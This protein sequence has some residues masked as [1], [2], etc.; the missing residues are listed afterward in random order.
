[1]KWIQ[2]EYREIRRIEWTT[3]LRLQAR[4]A[5]VHYERLFEND[6]LNT[7]DIRKAKLSF[8]EDS[9]KLFRLKRWKAR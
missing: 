5:A 3:F 4:S 1:M 7:L 2:L 8:Q 9:A 6:S